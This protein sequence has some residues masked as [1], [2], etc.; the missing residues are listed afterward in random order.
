MIGEKARRDFGFLL[1]SA[2]TGDWRERKSLHPAIVLLEDGV[3][4]TPLR[5]KKACTVVSV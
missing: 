3:G 4:E 1:P 5:S 2:L